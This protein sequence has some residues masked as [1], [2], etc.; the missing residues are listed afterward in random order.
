MWKLLLG[1][2]FEA[3]VAVSLA[4]LLLA[5]AIPALSSLESAAEPDF[6]TTLVVFGVLVAAVAIA[7][8]RPGSAIRRHFDRTDH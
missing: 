1:M 3:F 4:G 5:L 2:L 6:T 8:F 7:L